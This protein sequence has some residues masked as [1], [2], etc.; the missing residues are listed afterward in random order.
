MISSPR[1][2]STWLSRVVV[3]TMPS[4]PADGIAS[5]LSPPCSR[6]NIDSEIN[7]RARGAG[8][9]G[10]AGRAENAEDTT[11]GDRLWMS[12]VNAGRTL[13]VTVPTLYAYV[14]RG[15]IRSEPLPGVRRERRYAAADVERLRQR[16]E[17]RRDPGKAA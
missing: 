15:Y 10:A 2:P 4:R 8:K 7:M 17:A 1:S 9:K 13:G 14:S 11:R 3:A 16:A 5:N 12:A 6:V